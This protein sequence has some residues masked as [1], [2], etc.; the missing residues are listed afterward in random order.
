MLG[1]G[2]ARGDVLCRVL[3]SD[4]L[5]EEMVRFVGLSAQVPGSRFPALDQLAEFLC[6]QGGR[7]LVWP[8]HIQRQF[9]ALH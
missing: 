4:N 3:L 7:Q 9:V 2:P 5:V 1:N 6:A 8:S